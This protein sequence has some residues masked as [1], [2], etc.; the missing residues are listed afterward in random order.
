MIYYL[1]FR[2]RDQGGP[3]LPG[4]IVTFNGVSSG[5]EEQLRREPRVIFLIHGFN[6]DRASGQRNLTA[7]AATLTASATAA[8]VAVLWPGDSWA[9][10]L[11]YPLEGND[12][13]DTASELARYIK[14]ILGA[15]TVLSFVTH[16]L[17]ARVALETM[18]RLSSSQYPVAHSCFM[19]A[20]VDDDCVSAKRVYRAQIESAARVAILASQ[21]DKVLRF[22]YPAGDLLQSFIFFWRDNPGLA[23]GLHGPRASGDLPIPKAVFHTQIDDTHGVD[24]GDY[25]FGGVPNPKQAAA[26]RFADAVISGAPSPIY[27]P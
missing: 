5:T 18:K 9:N 19:A 6:V 8:I 3:V 11:S 27:K 25:L 16:S 13:D 22:A 4:R 24:H 7:F 26:G 17:G 12:A 23:L 21:K 20:A 1:D 2:G 15:G 10:A 14:R